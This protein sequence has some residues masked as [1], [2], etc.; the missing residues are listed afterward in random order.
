M[1]GGRRAGRLDAPPDGRR[2]D[3]VRADGKTAAT[4]TNTTTSSSA[5]GSGFCCRS[6]SPPPP[7]LLAD[8]GG[9]FWG[10]S[11][12]KPRC[13]RVTERELG[14]GAGPLLVLRFE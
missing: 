8:L 14:S 6:W 10:S 12:N 9:F 11:N 13:V 4:T 3:G 5:A 7:P 2:E 1:G